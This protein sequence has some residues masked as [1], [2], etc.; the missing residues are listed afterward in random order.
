MDVAFAA[1]QAGF[2]VRVYSASR[3]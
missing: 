1:A 3:Q 2:A